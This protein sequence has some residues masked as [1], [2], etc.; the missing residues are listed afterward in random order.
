MKGKQKHI[1]YGGVEVC[2]VKN[3]LTNFWVDVNRGR[4]S[5]VY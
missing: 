2:A 4:N 3:D 1:D 5:E